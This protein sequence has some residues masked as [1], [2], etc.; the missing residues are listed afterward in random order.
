M[1][2]FRDSGYIYVARST[3]PRCSDLQELIKICKGKVTTV[4][5]RAKIVVGEQI[6]GDEVV[7]VRETWVLDSIA[8]NKLKPIKNYLLDGDF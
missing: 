1:D 2:I 3:I 8:E 6:D 5:S 4:P 7:C